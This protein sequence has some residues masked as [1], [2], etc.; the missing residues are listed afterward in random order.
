MYLQVVVVGWGRAEVEVR[1]EAGEG[2]WE[3]VEVVAGNCS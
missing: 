1:E 3:V 2:G